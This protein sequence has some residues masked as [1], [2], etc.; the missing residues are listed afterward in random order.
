MSS[1]GRLCPYRILGIRRGASK[2]EI[3]EAYRRLALLN[4]PSRG[5]NPM[6][7]TTVDKHKDVDDIRKIITEVKSNLENNSMPLCEKNLLL[8]EQQEKE[9]TFLT[10]AAAFETLSDDTSRRR[11]D[12]LA[13]LNTKR[14]SSMRRNYD[15]GDFLQ[16]NNLDCGSPK[17]AKKSCDEECDDTNSMT[18]SA[19]VSSDICGNKLNDLLSGCSPTRL[20]STLPVCEDG[21]AEQLKVYAKYFADDEE[22]FDDDST[23]STHLGRGI[24]RIFSEEEN[25]G[26]PLHLMSKA[27]NHMNFTDPYKLF[28]SMFYSDI[29]QTNKQLSSVNSSLSP[30]ENDNVVDDVG[31]DDKKRVPAPSSQLESYQENNRCVI[32]PQQSTIAT[33]ENLSLST[34]QKLCQE[35]IYRRVNSSVLRKHS[36]RTKDGCEISTTVRVLDGFRITKTETSRINP[37]TGKKQ[38]TISVKKEAIDDDDCIDEEDC[39][40]SRKETPTESFVGSLLNLIHMSTS[41]K[42]FKGIIASPSHGDESTTASTC[43][44]SSSEEGGKTATSTAT[45]EFSYSLPTCLEMKKALSSCGFLAP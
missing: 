37:V 21:K 22:T 18:T 34:K 20:S 17:K 23:C 35:S 15:V 27:R 29:F 44:Y 3:H 45:T 10:Q 38:T 9:W 1:I 41:N 5:G 12:N 8:Q 40:C 13:S 30:I 33:P 28:N 31:T 24:D 26:G 43:C 42:T 6:S 25:F 32:S 11:Y 39:L 19:H 7:Q 4:H 2:T 16:R 36:T 14:S